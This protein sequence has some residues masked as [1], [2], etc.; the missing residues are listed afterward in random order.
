MM[1]VSTDTI[2]QYIAALEKAQLQASREEMPIP[3]N[4]LMM[5]VTKAM[6]SSER[7]PWA[8][9]DWE[10]LERVSKLW[11]KWCKLYKKEAMKETILIQEGGK[12][13][14]QFGGAALGRA[15]GG[16]NLQLD[17]PPRPPWKT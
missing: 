4:F 14:K 8:N 9:E 10:D 15:V 1:H 11:T 2:P 7:F 6:L 17:A 3:D 13:A 16:R 12:E 5:V